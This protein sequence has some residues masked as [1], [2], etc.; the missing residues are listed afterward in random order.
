MASLFRSKKDKSAKALPQ[1]PG[2]MPVGGGGG[3]VT[4][5]SV[6][7]GEFGA[8]TPSPS[9][10]TLPARPPSSQPPTIAPLTPP[11]S[12]TSPPLLPPKH[13]FLPT[14]I[15]PHTPSDNSVDS[16][17][18]SDADV[19]GL[20][21]YGFL[22]GVGSKI[23][24]GVEDVGRVVKD[25]G[26]E[27]ERRGLATPMLFSN[28]ALEL[29]QTRTKMLINSYLDTLSGTSRTRQEAF[30]QDIAFAKEHELAWLLRWAM[31]RVTR[32]KEGV[33]VLSHG[34]LEWEV[35]EEWRGRERAA[36]YPT[37]AF[38]FL[39]QLIPN[40]VYTLILV[41]LFHLL[42]RL[43]AHSHLTGL[44]PH[45][46]SSLFAPLLFVIPTSSPAL[47]SH[48][49]FVRSASAT[50]HLLL[51][52]VRSTTT[53]RTLVAALP[54]RLKEWVA[55]YPAMLASDGDLARGAPRRGARLIRCERAART[56]RAYT[57][58]LVAHAES[59]AGD[60]P[61]QAE[62]EAWDRVVWKA[63][64][65]SVARPKFTSGW[66]RLMMIKD[67]L[68]PPSSSSSDP[69]RQSTAYGRPLARSGSVLSTLSTQ[70]GAGAGFRGDKK[71]EA[72][73][74]R[75]G[76]LAGKEWSMFEEGGFD[77]PRSG[78]AGAG[79]AGRR[80]GGAGGGLGKRLQFDLNES[81]KLGIAERRQT[82]DWTEFASPSGGFNRTDPLLDVSLTFSQPVSSS[83]SAWPRERD[84]LRK[85]LHKA[86][87][88]A[89]PFGWDTGVR[90]GVDG[91]VY[92][93]E[94][95]VDFWADIG[96]GCGWVERE[97][98]TF[99]EANW[100]IIEY[101]AKPSR[102]EELAEPLSDPRTSSLYILFEERVPFEY[103]LA[104]ANPAQKKTFN[105][106]SPR[107]KK[108]RGNPT[109]PPTSSSAA[110]LA[111]HQA[112][113]SGDDFE[114]M[115]LSR[116]GT[117]K[118]SLSKSASDQPNT[119]VWHLAPDSG[120]P[121]SPSIA[122]ASPV[123]TPTKVHR[124]RSKDG[125]EG[126]GN[127]FSAG[128]KSK[129]LRRVKTDE[130]REEKEAEK[131]RK[132]EAKA[133]GSPFKRGG[134]GQKEQDVEFEMN[135][136]SG[137][138]SGGA[139]PRDGQARGAGDDDKWMDILVGGNRRMAG[140]DAPPPML[141]PSGPGAGANLG[142]PVSPYPPSRHASPEPPGGNDEGGTTP[143]AEAGEQGM[144]RQRSIKRKAVPHE[145]STGSTSPGGSSPPLSPLSPA[146]SSLAPLSPAS[147]PRPTPAPPAEATPTELELHAPRPRRE[148][149]TIH[150]IVA[151]YSDEPGRERASFSSSRTS[152]TSDAGASVADGAEG[153]TEG[154]DEE[155]LE[156]LE[157]A[158]EELQPPSTEKLFDLTPGREPSPA[159]YKHGEPL[160]FVGEEPE[161]E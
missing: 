103:Q 79:G 126:R 62:W 115:L 67:S 81:A 127:F 130:E 92:V 34:V 20:R 55:G 86:Q 4:G 105:L 118:V 3:L 50:E 48:A 131:E 10:R 17:H 60:L 123:K 125:E 120:L 75:W 98:L 147:H 146:S 161:E 114:R 140:Q 25:V 51:A 33:R 110:F 111:G 6:S 83:I 54:A 44:T 124:M 61:P 31:S 19:T 151:Q 64:R 78:S 156:A 117:K 58:D 59:W 11:R 99:R 41:P 70:S 68:P 142:L 113:G 159:R 134:A 102:P 47:V 76:S 77:A 108:A 87:K 24:L 107:S 8:I 74:A 14:H 90:V 43:A 132:L 152:R 160:H 42:S 66:K 2:S 23:V 109:N 157:D 141:K 91:R 154:G 106:F 104:I 129:G 53:A 35:Y 148:R 1:T 28:Q 88:D 52:Y 39:S 85:R 13:A 80:D 15:P 95:W 27:I 136:A 116:G 45:A 149:D 94:A 112:A 84:E 16:F 150:G 97:E 40:D 122:T 37:D 143:K 46:L 135:S 36:S 7:F 69:N 12:P 153:E 121:S 5:K 18:Y 96:M 49:T 9:S 89:V 133:A 21:A 128:K 100:A 57:K 137:I 63:R 72:E 73:E 30:K 22:G 82:M 158:D 119:S 93:E 38:P 138:S 144:E 32:V 26:E 65:G 56:V 155:T 29:N 145:I 71:D 101:K 139:S